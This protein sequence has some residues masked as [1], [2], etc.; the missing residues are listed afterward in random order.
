V[1]YEIIFFLSTYPPK[2]LFH[3]LC[4]PYSIGSGWSIVGVKE[5]TEPRRR[6]ELETSEKKNRRCSVRLF[7]TN[8]LK[9]GA[10]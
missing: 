10:M 4:G 5:K 3:F 9:E 2:I 7:E 6:H 8:S 1:I